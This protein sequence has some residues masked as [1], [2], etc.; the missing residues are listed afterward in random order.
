MFIALIVVLG[1]GTI[2]FGVLTVTF[3]NKAAATEKSTTQQKAA[4]AAAARDEQKSLDHI[5]FTKINETPYR[6]YNAPQQFGS[7]VINFPKNWSSS[8]RE[9]NS[10]TQVSLALNPEFIRNSNGQDEIT[11]IR[12]LF[13]TTPQSQY[14]AQYAG[15]IKNGKMKQ[16][17]TTVSGQ[18]AYDVTGT[19]SG[20][21]TIREVIVPVRDKVLVFSSE[22]PQ[23]AA[24]FNA[25]LSQAKIIP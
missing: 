2:I 21:K 7:F 1:L 24:E 18:P 4:A 19:F 10:G 3:S 9:Q 22:S 8:V 14:M 25:V 16:A 11:A 12:V 6:A 15:N 13:M 20:R 5:E 17:K 23:Y